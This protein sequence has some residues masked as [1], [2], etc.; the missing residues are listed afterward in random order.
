MNTNT[1]VILPQL[2]KIVATS[3][4][5]KKKNALVCTS[6]QKDEFEFHLALLSRYISI[7]KNIFQP[8]GDSQ[9]SK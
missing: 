9:W 1:N 8:L 4:S 3:Q 7:T 5:P 6:Y 2:F